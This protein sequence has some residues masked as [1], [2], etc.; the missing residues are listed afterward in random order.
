MDDKVPTV[1]VRVLGAKN[2][3]EERVPLVPEIVDALKAYRPDDYSASDLVFPNGVPRAG[4][5]RRDLETMASP[6][7]M[8]PGGT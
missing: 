8:N 6:T 3:K 5:L 2:K 7:V 1:R 4:R